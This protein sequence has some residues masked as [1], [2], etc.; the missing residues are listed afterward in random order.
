[1]NAYIALVSFRAGE[2]NEQQ[3]TS[4][5]AACE[6]NRA[7]K[8]RLFVTYIRDVYSD[9]IC[10]LIVV[11]LLYTGRPWLSDS[12]TNLLLRFAN[13]AILIVQNLF[14]SPSPVGASFLS[15]MSEM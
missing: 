7:N 10:T 12:L 6:H 15:T 1:M 13:A 5:S 4:G 11:P 9:I 2:A 14:H 3:R 8:L